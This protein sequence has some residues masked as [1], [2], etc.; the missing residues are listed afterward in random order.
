MSSR[1]VRT[2]LCTIAA[3]AV[4][5]GCVKEVEQPQGTEE[6]LHEVVFHAGWDAETKT[7][8]QEDGNIFW[9]PADSIVLYAMHLTEYGSSWSSRAKLIS[10]NESSSANA[11]F[12][13]DDEI[14]P[15]NI[16]VIMGTHNYCA[17]SPYNIDNQAFTSA[18]G[19][20]YLHYVLPMVQTATAESFD[21]NAFVCYAASTDTSLKFRNLCGGIKFSVSQDGIKEVAFRYGDETRMSGQCDATVEPNGEISI[22]S[23]GTNEVIVRAPGDSYLE[24]GKYYYAVM[25]PSES[26]SPMYVTYRKDDS[27]ATYITN[28]HT[29]IKRSTFKRLYDKDRDLVFT[30]IK[31]G[32]ILNRLLPESEDRSTITEVYFHPSSDVTSGINL[33]TEESPVYFV[34]EGSVVHYYT[35]EEHFL[36]NNTVDD[37]LDEV[38]FNWWRS[39]EKADLTGVDVSRLTDLSYFFADCPMLRTLDLRGFD[40]SNA[41]NM[42]HM[43][44]GCKNL[45]TIDISSFNTASVTN[46]SAMFGEC[47]LLREL[48]LSSFNT[49]K[50]TDMSWM[51]THCISLEKLDLSNMNIPDNCPID[52]ISLNLGIHR[53]HCSIR[54]SANTKVRLTEIRSGI[55]QYAMARYYTWILPG[56][57]FPIDNDPF[58]GYYTSSDYSK[59]MTSKRIHAATKGKGLDIVIMGDAYSDRL[60]SD[61]SYD[62]D[63]TNAIEQIFSEEPLKSLK[64]FFNVYVTY[65]VSEHESIDGRT[66]LNLVVGETSSDISGGTDGT[67]DMYI[68]AT[69]PDYGREY[70]TGRPI[71]FTIILS[72]CHKHGGVTKFFTSGSSLVMTS[73]GVSDELF[74]AVIC[75]EFG[76]AVGLLADEYDEEGASFTEP[77][78]IYDFRDQESKGFLPNIDITSDPSRVKWSRLLNDDRFSGQGLGI[79][80]GGYARYAYGVWRPT[81]N[82]IMNDALTGFNAPCREAIYKRVHELAFDNWTYDYENFV[83]FDQECMSHVQPEVIKT[84]RKARGMHPKSHA[85]IFIDNSDNSK[86]S[87]T[88]VIIK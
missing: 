29:S 78:Q 40:T 21:R 42:D 39:L 55:S 32:A 3:S 48:N 1:F 4:L 7:V 30:T 2:M 65:A 74:H 72:N 88:T 35:P 12:F 13:F 16:S 67:V 53:K 49:E 17:I 6:N 56:E 23:G 73:L 10:S 57:D 18:S 79:F 25:S 50:C 58:I 8:L 70:M 41:F 71:P 62:R 36:L 37:V 66:A 60:I 80:E 5:A 34:K 81:E 44:Y 26:D 27:E 33:G 59:D 77:W 22:A 69:L 28:G 75:H 63:M 54:C 43:F 47:R 31:K 84:S 83:S 15:G 19:S 24:K 82:S 68:R 87:C 46:M 14:G 20:I 64:E 86:G 61:G 45:E 85:P 11:E 52:N 9:E 51:F 38:S 76:H